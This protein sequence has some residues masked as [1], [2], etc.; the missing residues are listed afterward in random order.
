[1]E[2]KQKELLIAIEKYR[3]EISPEL[4]KDLIRELAEAYIAN[5]AKQ[6]QLGRII[7]KKFVD[8]SKQ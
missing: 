4:D 1:M 6:A 7:A 8:L 2:D 3:N 5:S